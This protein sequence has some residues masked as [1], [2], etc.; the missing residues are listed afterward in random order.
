MMPETSSVLLNWVSSLQRCRSIS[1]DRTANQVSTQAAPA[2][3]KEEE[4]IPH[5]DVVY[6]SVRAELDPS[7]VAKGDDD[8]EEDN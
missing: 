5:S 1:D 8:E 3:K 6:A 4:L 7:M 2:K